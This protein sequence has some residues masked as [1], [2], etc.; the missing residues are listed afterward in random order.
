MRS[1][2]WPDCLGGETSAEFRARSDREAAEEKKKKEA[3]RAAAAEAKRIQAASDEERHRQEGVAHSKE[4]ARVDKW[5]QEFAEHFPVRPDPFATAAIVG[6]DQAINELEIFTAKAALVLAGGITSI[7]D[8]GVRAWIDSI[9]KEVAKDINSL[10]LR[11][12]TVNWL[13]TAKGT[14]WECTPA[15][16]SPHQ[17][18]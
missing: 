12:A 14:L 6:T 3:E 4:Y 7:S 16:A 15:S 17:F 2:G 11:D 10:L 9:D 13:G 5:V 8:N 1:T 18:R